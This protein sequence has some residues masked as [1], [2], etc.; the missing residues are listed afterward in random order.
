MECVQSFSVEKL[1]YSIPSLDSIEE[2]YKPFL[3]NGYPIMQVNEILVSYAEGRRNFRGENLR[4]Q[5]FRGQDLS[6]ADFSGADLRGTNFRAA[7]LQGTQ[8]IGVKAGLQKRW[9]SAMLVFILT[10]VALSGLCSAL[11]GIL[12][13]AMLDNSWF[14]NMVAVWVSVVVWPIF[15]V[16]MIRRGIVVAIALFTVVAVITIVG[17]VAGVGMRA[18]GGALVGDTTGALVVAGVGAVAIA[19]AGALAIARVFAVTF[20]VTVALVVALDLVDAF[21]VG[22]ATVLSAI[23]ALLT[24]SVSFHVARQAMKGNRKYVVIRRFAVTFAAVG[25]TCFRGA[26]LTNA[27]FTGA[28]LKSADFREANLTRTIW[29]N[30]KQLDRIRPGKSIISQENVRELLVSGRLGYRQKLIKANLRGANLDGVDLSYTDLTQADLSQASLRQ[31]SLEG[32]ILSEANCVG[33]DFTQTKLTAA[34]LEAWNIDRTTV[35]D[36]IDCDYVF[37]L[38]EPHPQTGSRERRPHDP[39]AVF[40]PGDF[41]KLYR[42]I[43]N[44]VE[45]FLRN[46][47]NPDAFRQA[48]QH[49]MVDHPEIGYDSIQSIEKKGQDVFVKIAVPEETDKGQI[50][51]EFAEVYERRLEIVKQSALLEAEVRHNQNLTAIIHS[52]LRERPSNPIVHL[53]NTVTAES[54]AMNDN[55]NLSN[56]S[57]IQ[58]IQGNNNRSAKGNN[59]SFYQGDKTQTDQGVDSEAI[60][61]QQVAELLAYLESRIQNLSELP[62]AEQKRA[63]TRL[64]SAKVEAQE[65]EPDKESIAKSLKRVNEGLMESSTTSKRIKEFIQEVAPTVI[66]IAGWLGYAAGS[67]WLV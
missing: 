35:L 56:S 53:G 27:D 36:D 9:V 39:N 57:D 31:A 1:T 6:G 61:T 40:Q 42:Q 37:L 28:T 16:T 5:S 19:F 46:G 32:A 30:A 18:G 24:V 44:T 49:L 51:Q 20:T 62:E 26:D 60:T 15:L 29:R 3:L 34:C 4:G 59:S 14:E 43:M 58:F 65:S 64:A 41:E 45:I 17:V 47:I 55:V 8:F 48:F 33:A 23:L 22:K 13:F 50:E 25:G 2:S 7:T 67:I 10:L 52:A 54:K 63:I 21:S 12:I 66:K 11:A 38:Q